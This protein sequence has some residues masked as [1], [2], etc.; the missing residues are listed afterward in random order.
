MGVIIHLLFLCI[1]AVAATALAVALS[2]LAAIS[3]SDANSIGLIAFT[4]AGLTHIWRH[5]ERLRLRTEEALAASMRMQEALDR[6]IDALKG[7]M[8]ELEETME[9]KAERKSA[10]LVAELQ[11]LQSLLAEMAS[12]T[13]SKKP[14]AQEVLGQARATAQASSGATLNDDHLLKVI[15][16]ALEDNRLDLYIQPI[17]SLPQRKIRFLEVFSRV[18]D[19]VGQLIYPVDYIDVVEKSGL[20]VTLDNLL[21]FRCIKLIRQLREGDGDLS[22]FINVSAETIVDDRFFPQFVDFIGSGTDLSGRLIFEFSQADIAQA[23]PEFTQNLATLR[24]LGLRFSIDRTSSLNFDFTALSDQGFDFVK[25]AAS[26][27]AEDPGPI[28]AADLKEAFDRNNVDLIVD[29]IESEQML[30]DVLD[31][32]VDYGQGFLFGEPQPSKLANPHLNK[33]STPTSPKQATA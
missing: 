22:C 29:K 3:A 8:I 31:H 20:I 12:K 21:L 27:L 1:Y 19:E 10:E 25:V 26:L 11:V 5:G 33:T 2:S 24:S 17:V 30:V 14:S 23:T 7:D 32:S 6:D 18:R 9:A 4:L 16:N 15:E 28:Y 13:V